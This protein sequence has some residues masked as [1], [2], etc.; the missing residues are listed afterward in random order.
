MLYIFTYTDISI[1]TAFPDSNFNEKSHLR[2]FE[3]LQFECRFMCVIG[4]ETP[5]EPGLTP[6]P[7]QGDN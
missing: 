2:A 1:Q 4:H 7:L 5:P 6:Q 3:Y